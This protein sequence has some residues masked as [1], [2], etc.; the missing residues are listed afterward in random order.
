MARKTTGRTSATLC[1][2]LALAAG[3]LAA[4][5]AAQAQAS[6]GDGFLF[7]QPRAVFSIRGGLSRPFA[8]SDAFD[9]STQYLSLEKGDFTGASYAADLGFRLSNQVDLQ[10]GLGYSVRTVGSDSRDFIGTDDKPI[11]QTTRFR[12]VPATIGLKY[13][14]RPTGRSLGRLAWV[15][16]KWNPYLSAGGGA[17]YYQYSQFGE[18]VDFKDNSIFSAELEAKGWTPAGYG[19]VGVDYSLTPRIGLVTEARY[20]YA[21]GD[22]GNQFVGYDK[23]DLS[24]IA[25]TVGFNFRF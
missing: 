18:F 20:E 23:L 1:L 25:A 3:I 5:E 22:M 16:T 13:H 17:V 4:P 24:G 21:R 15:P 11:L 8:N 14:L 6:G 2:A 19:A 12:R 7:G 10:F 9:E